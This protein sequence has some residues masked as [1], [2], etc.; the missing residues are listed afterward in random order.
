VSL[1]IYLASLIN[2][3]M[4]NKTD[5]PHVHKSTD[6]EQTGTDPPPLSKYKSL[7]CISSSTLHF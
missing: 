4:K 7:S 3:D 5:K 6:V 2:K 1:M